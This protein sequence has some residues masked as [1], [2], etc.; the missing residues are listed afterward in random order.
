MKDLERRGIAM[1]KVAA[2]M[3]PFLDITSSFYYLFN[4]I[5][6]ESVRFLIE[7]CKN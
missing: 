5:L 3:K 2:V 6:V 7:S 1:G 4:P